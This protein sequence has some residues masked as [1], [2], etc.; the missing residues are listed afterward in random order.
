M[1]VLSVGFLVLEHGEEGIT[2]WE[3]TSLR[4]VF[5]VPKGLLPSI[6]QTVW[7][8]SQDRFHIAGRRPVVKRVYG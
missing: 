8:I 1:D 5:D 6:G 3:V 4:F 7:E 2:R